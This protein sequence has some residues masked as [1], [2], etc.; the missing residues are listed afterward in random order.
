LLSPFMF[1]IVALAVC[2]G[3][4]P[5][6]QRIALHWKLYDFPGAL[7]IHRKPIPRVGGIAMMA[8]LLACL[9]LLPVRGEQRL[10]LLA[11]LVVWA[12][13]LMDDIKGLPPLLRLVSHLVAGVLLWLGGWQLHWTTST[14]LNIGLTCLLVAFVINST[15]L[16]DGMDGL[17]AGTAGIIA[18]GFLALLSGTSALFSQVVAWSLLGVCLGVLV[19]NLPPASIFMGDSG[20]TLIGA[21]LAFLILDWTRTQPNHNI[22]PP[23]LLVS[24]PVADALLA[25][26][27]RLRSRKSPFSGDRRHFY[28]LLLQRGWSVGSVLALSWGL[29]AI[30]GVVAWCSRGGALSSQTVIAALAVA[31][32]F[33]AAACILGSFRPETKNRSLAASLKS[34]A[35]KVATV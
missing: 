4:M 7:K 23:L 27:R 3:A 15:N 28:D 19:R 30:L 10:G 18:I 11:F 35:E 31:T 12:V 34:N 29:T 8:G 26:V 9:V 14:A 5:M 24:L 17:A 32:A 33:S 20:S 25:A 2:I 13:G 21:L 1:G 22:V 6:G 16:F